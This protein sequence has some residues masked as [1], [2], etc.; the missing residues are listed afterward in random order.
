MDTVGTI[1]A[2]RKDLPVEVKEKKCKKKKRK[3]E[4][5]LFYMNEEQM[6]WLHN[7]EIKKMFP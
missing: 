1:C 6:L 4:K 3:K 5:Q 7:G 2:D